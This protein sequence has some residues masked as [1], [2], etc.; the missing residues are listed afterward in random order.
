MSDVKLITSQLIK[1]L[2]QKIEHANTIYILVSF[3]MKTGVNL[4]A[5]ALK[6][7]A[8]RGADIK[9]DQRIICASSLINCQ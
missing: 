6:R 9:F 4:L 7:A 8:E 3:S 2:V 1:D 5:P